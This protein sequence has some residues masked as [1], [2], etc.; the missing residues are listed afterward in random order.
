LR[1][2]AAGDPASLALTGAITESALLNLYRGAALL[3]YP[4]MYEGFG[5]PVLEAMQAGVP[6]VG[7]ACASVP[8]VAGDAALLVPPLE[9]RAWRDA[10]AAIATDRATERRLRDAGL[11][12]A[13][14][15]SWTHTAEETLAVL[16]RCA[17]DGK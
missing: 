12:R 14:R 9:V 11:A 15:F 16:R 2:A 6:V 5:L 13:A 7:A 3:V 1:A 17:E 4:S 8:E 10:I